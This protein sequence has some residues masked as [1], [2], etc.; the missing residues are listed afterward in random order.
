LKVEVITVGNEIIS[1]SILDTNF[2]FIARKL[3]SIGADVVWH[4]SV[5][6]DPETMSESLKLALRRADAVIVT[7][8]IGPTPD[9]ITRKVVSTVLGRGLLLNDEVLEAIKNR[10]RLRG[11]SMPGM[12]ERQ[13]LFPKGSEIIENTVG[14]APGFLIKENDRLLFVLPGVPVEAEAMMEQSVL[15]RLAGSGDLRQS[16]QLLFRTTGIPESVIAEN[17]ASLD[18][19]LE[20]IAVAYLPHEYGVDLS[21]TFRAVDPKRVI[22]LKRSLQERIRKILGQYCYAEDERKLEEVVG[23]MLAAGRLT[24]AVA[25]SV[26]G[27]TVAGLVTSVPGASRYFVLGVAAYSNE[28]KMSVLKVPEIVLLEKGAVSAEVA[29]EMA[30]GVREKGLCDVGLS[31][32]GIAGPDGGSAEKPVGLVYIAV[33][34]QSASSVRELRLGGNRQLIIRRASAAALDLV[35]RTLLSQEEKH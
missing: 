26:T 1:G 5:G 23:E 32:T 15:P 6:D 31:T 4:T 24:L 13:A 7:G 20:G 22:P 17:M 30:N 10:F 25:E 8:G 28:V 33:V 11:L 12:N 16:E 21:L 19:P 29:L 14:L 27:G 18:E 9:D 35:R 3:R 34:T 2:R